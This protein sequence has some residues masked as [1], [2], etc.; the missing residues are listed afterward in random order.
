VSSPLMRRAVVFVLLALCWMLPASAVAASE[1]EPRIVL[2]GPVLVDRGERSGDIFVG[3][4]DVT[5]RGSVRGDIIVGDGDVT[6]RGR[7]TGDVLTF[8]GKS[9]LGRRAQ[10]GGDLI[11]ATDKPQVASGATVEGKLEKIDVGDY[12]GFGGIAYFVFWLA[13]TISVL[14]LGLLLLALAPRAAD[15]IAAGAKTGKVKPFLWGLL[16]FFLIP[17]LAAL[18]ILTVVGFPLGVGLLLALI[19]IYALGYTAAAF[20]VGR[21]IMSKRGRILAFVV[22]VIILRL[23]AL[24]PFVSSLIWFLATIFGLGAIFV[25]ILRARK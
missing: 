3:Q 21:L 14:V 13:A 1:D 16:L 18:C 6:I 19:P 11:Y 25:A 17:I 8:N 2:M 12:G 20:I 5:V 22:G 24:I 4:G 9:I 15:A 7:V 23:L 10:V